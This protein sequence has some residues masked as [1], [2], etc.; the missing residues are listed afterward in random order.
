[1]ETRKRATF[2]KIISK[3]IVYKYF[4][5]FSNHKNKTWMQFLAVDLLPMFLNTEATGEAFQQSGKQYSFTQILK[6]SASLY[7]GSG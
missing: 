3:P 2:L 4:K 5:E 7:A 6:S 1:M